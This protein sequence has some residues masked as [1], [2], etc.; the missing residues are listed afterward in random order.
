MSA[1]SAPTASRANCST[2][3]RIAA[4]ASRRARSA[5][6]YSIAVSLCNA[7]GLSAGLRASILATDISREALERAGRAV[8]SWRALENL[9]PAEIG[10][11]FARAGDEYAV[12]PRLRGMV[13]FTPMNLAQPVYQGRFD[14]IF[15]MNVLIYF[16]DSLR[17]KLLQ[18]FYD[19]LEPGGYLCLGHAESAADAPVKF[20]TRFLNGARLLQKPLAQAAGGMP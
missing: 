16:G 10:A 9:S 14:C 17:S 2:S 19:A 20:Q 18:R 12:K 1:P 5:R 13:K 4:A 11:Y 3:A 6:R 7:A 8:Y 15:C